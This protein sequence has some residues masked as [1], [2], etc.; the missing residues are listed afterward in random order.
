MAKVNGLDWSS[1]NTI[2]DYQ[3]VKNDPAQYKFVFVK[4]TEGTG[5]RANYQ[6]Q[7]DGAESIGLLRGMYHFYRQAASPSYQAAYFTNWAKKGE[8][9]PVLDFEDTDGLKVYGGRAM[10]EGAK[11]W[12]S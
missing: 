11:V 5:Y 7:M 1:W 3:A 6:G 4:A 10:F 12:L 2:T 8:L 9:P